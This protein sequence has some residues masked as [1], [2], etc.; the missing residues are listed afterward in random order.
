M[1]LIKQETKHITFLIISKHQT[2]IYEVPDVDL[3]IYYPLKEIQKK[4]SLYWGFSNLP[5]VLDAFPALEIMMWPLQSQ[6]MH[7]W[8]TRWE[9]EMKREWMT[10]MLPTIWSVL[11]R[12]QTRYKHCT[13]AILFNV[14]HSVLSDF[15]AL[16]MKKKSLAQKSSLAH[17]LHP[18]TLLEQ[19]IMAQEFAGNSSIFLSVLEAQVI[20][21]CL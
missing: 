9:Q 18:I 8:K 10:V 20:S 13:C 16:Q 12:G 3:R 19:K 4:L 7:V 5:D 14:H 17:C 1:K 21:Q 6:S 11:P 15:P 2:N